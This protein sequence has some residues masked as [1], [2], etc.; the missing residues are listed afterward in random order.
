VLERVR[1]KYDLPSKFIFTLSS[2]DRG[3]RKN[4]RGILN[5]YKM[6]HGKTAHSLVIGGKDCHKFKVD[7]GMSGNGFWSDIVLPGWIDQADLPAVYSMA[8]AFLYPSNV[9]AFPIPITEAL[10]CGT[11]IITSNSNGLLEIVGDAALLVTPGD[12][13]EI[14]RAIGLLLSNPE[15]QGAISEK[16]LRRATLFSW[17]KCARQTLDIIRG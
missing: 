9:E 6:H 3:E 2:Y 15:L 8:D 12:H 7:Y 13:E 17:D 10:S 1:A 11:P 14:A 4:I 16:G 5:A